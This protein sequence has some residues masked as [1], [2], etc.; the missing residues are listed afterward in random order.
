[1]AAEDLLRLAWEAEHDGRRALRD[2]LLTLAVAESGPDDAWAERCRAR[3][4][5]ERPDHFLG[6]FATRPPGPGRPPGG[7]GSR[8]GSGGNIPRPGSAGSC[9]GPGRAGA[10]H[11][12]G[13]V[14][15]GDDRGPR[16]PVAA[17]AENVRRDAAQAV[18][19]PLVRHRAAGPVG[20]SL[21][22]PP[23]A[24][25]VEPAD[26][27]RRAGRRQSGPIP[28]RR[29]TP[30]PDVL[31]RRSS[32]PIAMLAGV[33][34]SAEDRSARAER[35]SASAGPAGG[36]PGSARDGGGCRGSGP[37]RAG[38]RGPRWWRRGRPGRCRG[39]GAGGRR[40]RAGAR[41]GDSAG[42]PA[43]TPRPGGTW[44]GWSGS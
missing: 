40:G 13:R 33:E 6:E 8:I 39:G 15:R 26:G 19:G 5:A 35:S 34:P 30:T 44:W 43:E 9:S 11:R 3:L 4:V 14:A 17:E 28:S 37:R 20:L 21:A 10:L 31:P 29:S 24:G 25:R 42:A 23:M 41:S 27:R 2:A 12:P 22:Y 7:R 36:R 18:R 16:R 1:M 38:G 32:S